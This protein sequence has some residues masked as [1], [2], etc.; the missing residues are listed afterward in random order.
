LSQDIDQLVF[1]VHQPE[2]NTTWEQKVQITE[3][4]KSPFDLNSF[5]RRDITR[6][7]SLAEQTL[8]ERAQLKRVDEEEFPYFFLLN[9]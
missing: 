2:T 5:N 7:K 8:E 4:V 9:N 3:C 1:R 6:L